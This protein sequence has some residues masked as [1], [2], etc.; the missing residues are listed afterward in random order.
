MVR[1]YDVVVARW[2]YKGHGDVL[3]IYKTGARQNIVIDI[4]IATTSLLLMMMNDH[5]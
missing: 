5:Y 2:F 4:T 3:L 1:M